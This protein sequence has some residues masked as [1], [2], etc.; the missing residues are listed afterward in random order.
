[1]E[2]WTPKRRWLYGCMLGMSLG[3]IVGGLEL[4]VR[5]S[6]Q[7][8]PLWFGEVFGLGVGLCLIM[9]LCGGLLG[10]AFGLLHVWRP[11][12]RVERVYAQQLGGVTLG[13]AAVYFVP[14]GLEMH[15][16]GH[17]VVGLAMVGMSVG[18]AAVVML[19]ARYWIRRSWSQT[20]PG[21]GWWWIAGGVSGVL[22]LVGSL[23][24]SHVAQAGMY[25]LESDRS[26]LLVTVE[27]A[28][29]DDPL[30]PSSSSSVQFLEMVTPSPVA[31]PAHATL[32]TGLHPLRSRVVMADDV[33]SAGHTTVAEVLEEEGY[34]TGAFVSS[35]ALD[36]SRGLGQGFSVYDDDFSTWLPGWRKTSLGGV[37]SFFEGSGRSQ[38]S[39]SARGTTER[40]VRWLHGVNEGTWLAWVHLV[41]SEGGPSVSTEIELLIEAA[42]TPD[43]LIMV[44]GTR[45]PDQEGPPLRE[46]AI[47]VPFWVEGARGAQPIRSISAQVRLMDFAPTLVDA[48]KL[49]EMNQSEGTSLLG[50]ATGERTA[51][52]WCS[53][54]EE[55]VH[56]EVWIGMRNNGLKY[57]ESPT[58]ERELYVLA[59]DPYEQTNASFEQPQTVARAVRLLESEHT[60]LDVLLEAR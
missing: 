10:A 40:A 52:M 37:W 46:G 36:Q 24:G 28:A 35:D 43:A 50:Y 57:I 44:V 6:A 17:G 3:W 1:M 60:A 15:A 19:N 23:N 11:E 42:D 51:T 18:F 12:A 59:D 58:G 5:F 49:P 14:I 48:L 55:D 56:G 29:W 39:R 30:R 34:A 9:G 31:M 53:L 38:R 20:T 4:V 33:L 2:N 16:R 22:V 8:L 26:V 54:V 21:A 27:G 41:Q 47:R 7:R 45:G 32:M 13:L 25:A